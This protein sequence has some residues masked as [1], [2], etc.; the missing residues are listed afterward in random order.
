MLRENETVYRRKTFAGLRQVSA[1]IPARF[2]VRQVRLTLVQSRVFVSLRRTTVRRTNHPPGDEG[3][4]Y[5]QAGGDQHHDAKSENE[6]LPNRELDGRHRGEIKAGGG[7]ERSQPALI[8]KDNFDDIAGELEAAQGVAES[9]SKSLDHND[10]EHRNCQH[11]RNSRDG[12]VDARGRPRK[13]FIH[14]SHYDSG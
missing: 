8:R 5:G 6:R 11:A 7:L 1:A 3:A 4:S 10:P 12:I 9:H 14:G 13:I 2:F